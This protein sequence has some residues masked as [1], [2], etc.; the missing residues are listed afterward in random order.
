MPTSALRPVPTSVGGRGERFTDP[1]WGVT[2]RLSPLETELLRSAP[3]RRLHLVAH[4]GASSITTLQSYSRLEHSLGVLALAAHFRPDDRLLRAAALLHDVGH[5]PFSHSLEGLGGWDHHTIGARLL[6]T[7]PLA[8]VLERHG[9]APPDVAGLLDRR[10][11]GVLAPPSGLLGLDHLDSYVRSARCGARLP[12]DP[13]ELLGRVRLEGFAVSGD[14]DAAEAL[15]TMVRDEALLH[16]SW[17]NVAPTAVLQRVVRRLLSADGPGAERT[18][19]LTDDELWAALA[20]EPGTAAEA[21]LLRGAPHLVG[22]TADGRDAPDGAWEF[23]LRKIYTA[24][25]LVGGRPVEEAA[26]GLAERIALLRRLPTRYRVWWEDGAADTVPDRHA[27][28]PG[29]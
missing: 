17:D 8:D 14:R 13:A 9:V 21:A 25:P 28:A 6:G 1:L 15:V 24:A 19:R 18:A 7:A 11:P 2:V 4:G 10:E 16:T 22:A 5:L 26:P 27:G 20:A 23:S 29:R 3:V 12:V